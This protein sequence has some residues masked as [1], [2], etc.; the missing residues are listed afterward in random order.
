MKY[1]DLERRRQEAEVMQLE[2]EARIKLAEANHKEADATLKALEVRH[3]EEQSLV[4]HG[5]ADPKLVAIVRARQRAA[6]QRAA[7]ADFC[8]DAQRERMNRARE[9]SY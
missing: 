5:E 3:R 1:D 7:E 9:A 2:A 8:D 4:E 6:D